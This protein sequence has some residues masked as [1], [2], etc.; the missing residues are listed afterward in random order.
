MKLQL[1][2][3]DQKFVCSLVNDMAT[4][5]TYEVGADYRIH[6]SFYSCFFKGSSPNNYF[7]DKASMFGAWL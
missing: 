6:V 2:D 4:L 1:F 7:G 3:L 5:Q